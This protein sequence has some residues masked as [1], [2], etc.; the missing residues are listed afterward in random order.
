MWFVCTVQGSKVQPGTCCL[1]GFCVCG[2]KATSESNQGLLPKRTQNQGLLYS[3]KMQTKVPLVYVCGRTCRLF[4]K[5][6]HVGQAYFVIFIIRFIATPSPA[7]PRAGDLKL[8]PVKTDYYP[9]NSV[10]PQKTYRYL[11]HQSP[12]IH[13]ILSHQHHWWL[14]RR[15]TRWV[16]KRVFPLAL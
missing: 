7:A 4:N 5:E 16:R 2:A 14:C 12:D 1:S 10:V 13:P 8:K 15:H 6:V 9:R 11:R 3:R